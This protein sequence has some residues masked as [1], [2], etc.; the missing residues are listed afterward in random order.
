MCLHTWASSVALHVCV[1]RNASLLIK[2]QKTQ[3]VNNRVY[4]CVVENE[5]ELIKEVWSTVSVVQFYQSGR[6][7]H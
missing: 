2:K 5:R 3:A 1:Q 7:R 4:V 6:K